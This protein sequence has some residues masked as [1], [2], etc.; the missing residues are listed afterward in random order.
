MPGVKENLAYLRGCLR[1]RPFESRQDAS[2]R[3]EDF[4]TYLCGFCGK[5]HR[6]SKPHLKRD[7]L[8]KMKR[9]K[10]LKRIEALKRQEYFKSL[11]RCEDSETTTTHGDKI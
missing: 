2:A 10:T 5:W 4:N 8:L 11:K 7:R 1:K 6:A 9:E 3:A